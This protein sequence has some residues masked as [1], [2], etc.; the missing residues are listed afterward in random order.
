M[1]IFAD[2]IVIACMPDYTEKIKKLMSD[3]FKI[4]WEPTPLGPTWRRYL[5]KEYRR[6]VIDDKPCVLMRVPP[7]Y[8]DVTLNTAGMSECKSMATPGESKPMVEDK[9]EALNTDQA[10]LYRTLIGRLMWT[11]EARPDMSFGIKECARMVSAP[12]Q[13]SWKQLQHVLRYVQ[14]TKDYVL[15]LGDGP[16]DG[17]DEV[18]AITDA[19]WASGRG[20]K[21]T[22]AALIF[23]RGVLLLSMSRTQGRL[24]LSSAEAEL[25]AMVTGTQ[26]AEFVTTLMQEIEVTKQKPMIVLHGDSNAALGIAARIGLGR[27][28]HVELRLLWLQDEVRAGTVRMVKEVTELIEAD[29]LTK[30]LNRARHEMLC[31][32]VG[33]IRYNE[34]NEQ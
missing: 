33:L 19:S 16:R 9:T 6:A 20:R 8:W 15:K 25:E 23:F 22:T 12:T 29:L 5:G 7:A 31:Q 14:G 28:K 30:F 1:M 13:D 10:H 32:R 3:C 24:A 17:D 27:L 4:K 21:S 2:D 11:I 18:T 34:L 26:E